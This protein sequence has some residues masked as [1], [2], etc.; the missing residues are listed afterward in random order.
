LGIFDVVGVVFEE[1]VPIFIVVEDHLF[2]HLHEV[3]IGVGV[4]FLYGLELGFHDL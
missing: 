4:A 3:I 2:E 1:V